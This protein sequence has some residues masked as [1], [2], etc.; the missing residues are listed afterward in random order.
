M[1]KSRKLVRSLTTYAARPGMALMA[2]CLTGC[3]SV[4]G[5]L[6][7]SGG[8]LGGLVF[9][10]NICKSGQH[11]NF[12]GADLFEHEEEPASAARTQ[13]DTFR[14]VNG[15][16]MRNPVVR[17]DSPT[18][19]NESYL[20]VINDVV[21][22]PLVRFADPRLAT[23]YLQFTP[24]VCQ[25]LSVYAYVERRLSRYPSTEGTVHMQCALPDG[26]NASGALSFQQCY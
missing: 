7:L 3:V 18:P 2:W 21:N 15:V 14:V 6:K 20:R 11:Y 23:G 24:D 19:S 12:L 1:Q 10:P 17:D 9:K 8:P 4:E 5:T 26:T 16:V 25:V 13:A 22:G